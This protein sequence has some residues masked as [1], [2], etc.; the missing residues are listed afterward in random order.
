M[1]LM[2]LDFIFQISSNVCKKLL[3]FISYFFTSQN[4]FYTAN[5]LEN[6]NAE[7]SFQ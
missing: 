4:S 2:H 5:L 7:V 6:T 1:A 3:E